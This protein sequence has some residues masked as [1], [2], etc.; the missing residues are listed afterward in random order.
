MPVSNLLITASEVA[1]LGNFNEEVVVRLTLPEIKAGAWL[2]IGRVVIK[3]ADTDAQPRS[4]RMT[5]HDGATVLDQVE[6]LRVDSLDA[7]W[8][9]QISLYGTLLR[10]DV[11][12]P[13]VDLRASTYDGLADFGRLFA[14]LVDDVQSQ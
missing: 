10:E 1:D 11:P 14:L 4:A 2:L 8:D 6:D 3:N 13:I 12:E 5:T 7:D 9:K